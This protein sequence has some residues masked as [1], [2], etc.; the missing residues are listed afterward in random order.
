MVAYM[1][2]NGNENI[3]QLIQLLV[4][5]YV[6]SG[7][8]LIFKRKVLFSFSPPTRCYIFLYL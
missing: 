5:C 1:I 4:F 8:D 6:S 2:N 3:N 7:F